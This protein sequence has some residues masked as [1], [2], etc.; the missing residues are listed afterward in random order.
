M[1]VTPLAKFQ[2]LLRKL[3]QFDCADLDFGS[4]GQETVVI[5]RGIE[6]WKP[7]DYARE[8]EWVQQQEL[9]EGAD[10]VYVNGDSVIE[11]ACSLDPEFKHRMFE[12]VTA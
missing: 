9:I 12:G 7:E 1:T 4:G 3:F 8:R 10:V 5:W 6:G 11:G 2:G